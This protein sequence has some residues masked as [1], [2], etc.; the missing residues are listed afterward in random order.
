[1]PKRQPR[2]KLPFTKCVLLEHPLRVINAELVTYPSLPSNAQVEVRLHCENGYV[3]YGSNRYSGVVADQFGRGFAI[4]E[5]FKNALKHEY[6]DRNALQ[7][8]KALAAMTKIILSSHE[9]EDVDQKT[10]PAKPLLSA[11]TSA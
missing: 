10:E 2:K 11:S 7:Q 4:V 8:A 5:A 1:M 6:E 9:S 3:Y